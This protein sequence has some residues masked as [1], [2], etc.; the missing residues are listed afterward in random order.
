MFF[1]MFCSYAATLPVFSISFSISQVTSLFVCQ[2]YLVDDCG[3]TCGDC[4][5][6]LVPVDRQMHQHYLK[7]T[8]AKSQTW[9]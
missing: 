7:I 4:Q 6:V 8:I 5:E 2:C 1:F 9:R 3:R